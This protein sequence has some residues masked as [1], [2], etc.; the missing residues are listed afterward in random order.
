[1]LFATLNGE[2]EMKQVRLMV[3]T[4]VIALSAGCAFAQSA[5]SA[6]TGR[7]S[8]PMGARPAAS[9]PGKR[10]GAGMG[11]GGGRHAMRGEADT[12]LGWSLMTTQ[13]GTQHREHMRAMK[14][15][16]ECKT[17][18]AQ[19]HEE[20]AARAKERGVKA[21]PMPRRDPCAGLSK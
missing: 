2:F 17:Y 9:E 14:T 5:S 15:Q 19:H 11:F 6:G 1:M 13:D 21:L 8:G 18:V 3:V 10:P 16:D 4:S 7:G 20:M 12:T